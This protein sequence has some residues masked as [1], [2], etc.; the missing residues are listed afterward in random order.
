MKILVTG[1]A[2]FI[3][4]HLVDRLLAGKHDVYV[5]DDLS[6]GHPQNLIE[7]AKHETFHFVKMDVTRPSFMKMCCDEAFDVIY[8]LA[9]FPRIFSFAKPARDVEVNVIGMVNVIN[10]TLRCKSGAAKVIFS[11]N[12]G[13]YDT[14]KIPINELTKNNPTTPYDLDK[15]QAENY[16]KL[17]AKTYKD[18]P[19]T[20][21]RFGTVYGPRQRAV[22]TWRPVV[23]TF[24]QDFMFDCPSRIDGDGEQ[25]RDLVYVDDVVDALL[26]VAEERYSGTSNGETMILGT[27]VETS[28]NKIYEMVSKHF[29]PKVPEY[30]QVHIGDIKRMCYDCTKANAIIGWKAKT[31]IE[32]GIKKTVEWWDKNYRRPKK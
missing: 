1:G 16:L 6:S 24:A 25:T 5:V 31:P 12:S 3:G 19:F 14:S 21:F 9:C 18:P 23:A 10:G 28:V 8:H 17:Y 30:G 15:L 22:G 11:S 4:S 7:A 27:G 20:I 2:G 29:G 13:I 26:M 32:E